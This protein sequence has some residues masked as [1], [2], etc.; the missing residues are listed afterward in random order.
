[1]DLAT[2]FPGCH[3]EKDVRAIALRDS[4]PIPSRPKRGARSAATP[5]PLARPL[6]PSFADVRG[7]CRPEMQVRLFG[8]GSNTRSRC[9]FLECRKGASIFEPFTG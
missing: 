4:G 9:I 7:G 8:R 1:M 5:L 2:P 3:G 6:T